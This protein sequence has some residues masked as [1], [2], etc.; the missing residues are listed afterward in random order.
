MDALASRLQVDPSRRPSVHWQ[1]GAPS[2]LVIDSDPRIA[3]RCH[4]LRAD[5]PWIVEL[6]HISYPANIPPPLTILDRA[7]QRAGRFEL[8]G[9]CLIV[10]FREPDHLHSLLVCVPPARI[11]RGAIELRLVSVVGVLRHEFADDVPEIHRVIIRA[12]DPNDRGDGVK[13]CRHSLSTV[14]HRS[15]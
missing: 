8:S 11:E 7:Y 3:N 4:E 15:T 13:R 12:L 5:E 14:Q 1:R 10:H 9:D 2:G 6:K